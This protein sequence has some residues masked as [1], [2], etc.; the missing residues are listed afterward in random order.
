MV[1]QGVALL[2][3]DQASWPDADPLPISC[4]VDPSAPE[5]LQKL[6]GGQSHSCSSSESLDGAPSGGLGA[7][8]APRSRMSC[9]SSGS[10]ASIAWS[11][12]R[13][14]RSR[15]L[16]SW[17]IVTGTRTDVDKGWGPDPL[18]VQSPRPVGASAPCAFSKAWTKE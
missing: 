10:S 6:G 1:A 7:G 12:W 13:R 3:G 15:R 17:V 16:M 5:H 2:G 14:A 11:A 8:A 18:A 9:A 4:D